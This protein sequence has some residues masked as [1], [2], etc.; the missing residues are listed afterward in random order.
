M[1][2]NTVLKVLPLWIQPLGKEE[3]GPKILSLHVMCL[4][5]P[6]AVLGQVY[7]SVQ[8]AIPVLLPDDRN[9]AHQSLSICQSTQGNPW[10]WQAQVWCNKG[11]KRLRLLE[12]VVVGC[13]CVIPFLPPGTSHQRQEKGKNCTR[14]DTWFHFLSV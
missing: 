1:F 6:L 5:L 9:I 8:L 3:K 13:Q 2:S 4:G 10:E 14:L 11:T 12:V 7:S